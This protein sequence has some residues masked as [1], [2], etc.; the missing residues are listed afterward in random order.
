MTHAFVTGGTG[1]IGRWLLPELTKRGE[2]TALVRRAADR[3]TELRAWVTAHGG[4]ADALRLVDGDLGA[5]GLGLDERERARIAAAT[6]DY[7]ALGSVMQ[8]GL[9]AER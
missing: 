5:P 7:Y 6:T 4:N 8:F 2:V 9:D 1:L 3:G